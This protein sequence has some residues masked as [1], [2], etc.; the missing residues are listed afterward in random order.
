MAYYCRGMKGFLE[1]RHKRLK[2]SIKCA[3]KNSRFISFELF[4]RL[5]THIL[6]EKIEKNE[7]KFVFVTVGQEGISGA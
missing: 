4:Q 3:D 5:T 2:K 1:Q 6:R 7:V